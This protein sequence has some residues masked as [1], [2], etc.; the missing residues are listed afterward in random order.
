M[1]YKISLP[2]VNISGA[3]RN[4]GGIP[5]TRPRRESPGSGRAGSKASTGGEIT[6]YNCPQ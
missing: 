3:G 1:I 2:T 6:Y 4:R 5:S